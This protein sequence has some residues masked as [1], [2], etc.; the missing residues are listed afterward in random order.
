MTF[1]RATAL[2]VVRAIGIHSLF[3]LVVGA[4]WAGVAWFQNRSFESYCARIAK[5]SSAESIVSEARAHG[6]P[7]TDT[8]GEDGRIFILNHLSPFFRFDCEVR[9]NEGRSSEAR[10]IFAD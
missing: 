3:I 9:I 8:H 7:V 6:W 2:Y 1:L 10:M 4:A 5:G